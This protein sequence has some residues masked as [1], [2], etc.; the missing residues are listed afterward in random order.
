VESALGSPL[1]AAA[2]G[3]LGSLKQNANEKSRAAIAQGKKAIDQ[4]EARLVQTVVPL[5]VGKSGAGSAPASAQGPGSPSR[6][7]GPSADP[8]V[9]RGAAMR[10]TIRRTLT[11]AAQRHHLDPKL[12]LALA[13]WESGWDQSRV[14]QTGAVGLMQVEPATAQEAGPALLGRQIDI[15]DPYDNADLG[16]AVLR[17]DLDNFKDPAMALAAYYQGPTSLKENGMLPETQQYVQG[18]LDLASRI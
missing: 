15:N 4:V 7:R 16:A 18:I 13:Y 11:E 3:P 10:A 6:S 14:S 12:V 9:T 8:E 5:P 1:G 17:E 2:E